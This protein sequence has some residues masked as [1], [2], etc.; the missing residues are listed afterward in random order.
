MT[1]VK[2]SVSGMEVV[3]SHIEKAI[4][5]ATEAKQIWNENF[6]NLY[7]NFKESGFLDELYKDAESQYYHF[8]NLGFLVSY[9]ATGFGSGA[10]LGAIAGSVIPGLGNIAIGT[11]GGIVGAVIGF[12]TGIHHCVKNP[13]SIKW[14]YVSQQVF[15][16]LLYLCA[17]GGDDNSIYLHDT[18][19]KIESVRASMIEIQTKINEFQQLYANLQNTAESFGLK[20]TLAK[21]GV[22]ML[23]VDT[24]VT[25]NN[26]KISLSV[27][28]AMN[29]FFTY[30]STTMA[31]EIEADYMKRTYGTSFNYADIV[32][33]A[34]GFMTRTITSGLYSHEFVNT[35][36]PAYAI[37]SDVANTVALGM[38][39]KVTNFDSILNSASEL[40]NLGTAAG[41]VGAGFLGNAI[42]RPS[43]SGKGGSS[44]KK[45][46]VKEEVVELPP[47]EE[48]LEGV[49]PEKVESFIEV[50]YDDLARAAYEAQDE[51]ELNEHV[52][53]VIEEALTLFENGEFEKIKERLEEFG[54]SLP[55]IESIIKNQ[56]Y[57]TMAF[58]EGDRRE[59]LT[60]LANRFADEDGIKDFDTSYDDGQEY[61]DLVDGT[62]AT[63]LVNMSQDKTIVETRTAFREAEKQY[64]ESITL[65]NESVAASLGAKNALDAIQKK[66]GSDTTHWTVE[67]AES[68]NKIV[69]E[70]NE[71]LKNA[72]EKVSI[73]NEAKTNYLA[74]KEKYDEA[75]K[76]FLDEI[77]KNKLN[78]NNK[79]DNTLESFVSEDDSQSSNSSVATESGIHLTDEDALNFIKNT[80][81][82]AFI[83]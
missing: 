42:A 48:V 32:K 79:N 13:T 51:E 17:Q 1:K 75:K 7:H 73:S 52:N 18:L 29:A 60:E 62:N 41:L 19:G 45:E 40:G 55:E 72:N 8:A 58:V 70:Y 6:D 66:L 47:L 68:Y 25:I 50:D 22:T 30:E 78:E 10:G 63:L 46:E 49:V 81:D 74:T 37:P 61:S 31:S 34:N 15:V 44:T 39:V 2:T 26:E 35:L 53:E 24:E 28:E 57:V 77:K 27:S 33:N 21:D 38:G 65:A 23:S 3:D 67:D 9:T 43:G 80:N 20:T 76:N 14:S 64:K 59:S 36:L 54:Y 69:K 11:I 4:V 12:F 83:E 82:S 5:A 16:D 56:E 71:A